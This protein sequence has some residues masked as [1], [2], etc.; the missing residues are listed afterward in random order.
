MAELN[1]APFADLVTRLYR[2]PEIQNTLFHLPRRSWH[3]P[4]DDAPDFSVQFHSQRAGNPIGPAAGPHTQM[5][6]NILLSYLAGSR[7]IELKTVQ[8]DDR[9]D[10]GRPCIDMT[11]VGYNIEFSQELLV[12]DSLREYVAGM[13]LIEMLRHDPKFADLNL[14]NPHGDVLY[15]T[16][17]GYDL[18]GIRSDKVQRFLDGLND[19]TV[20]IEKLRNQ[21]PTRFKHARDIDYPTQISTSVTLS[22]FHGCPADE[23]ERICT[24]LI[25]DRNL[26]VIVKMNPPMLGKD[27]LEHILHDQ[28][29]YTELTVNPSAY[30]T[31]LM[32][33]E[34]VAMNT[35]LSALA[36]KHNRRFGY[37]FSNTLEVINHRDFF[38]DDNKV[39]YLSGQPLHVIALTL[40]DI[41]RQTVGPNVPIT[42]SAGIDNQN[43]ADTV[44][45]GFVPITVSSD[46]LRPGGYGRLAVYFKRLADAMNNVNATNINDFVLD[47]FNQRDIATQKATQHYGDPVT[48]AAMLNTTIAAEN[49]RN[50]AR[51]HADK[52][53]KIQKRINSHLDVFDCIT[54]DKCIPV[55]P[56]AANFTY[57]TPITAFDHPD[58]VVQ[59]DGSVVE[60]ATRQFEITEKMQIACYAD[61]CNECGNCDTFCPEYGGP[62]IKK[63]SFFGSVKSYTDAAPRD[64]FVATQTETAAAIVGR[65]KSHEYHLD[66]DNRTATAQYNDGVVTAQI[67]AT[68]HT[69][70]SVTINNSTAATPNHN[71]DMNA[72]HTLRH[73]LAGVLNTKHVNQINAAHIT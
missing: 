13:M 62:Y 4:A 72:Y 18:A 64:G 19:A 49:A 40:T 14:A 43:I 22:T 56:N 12:Y 44:A 15:D 53:R 70:K 16:S 50:D 11:N 34:S 39:M 59:S 1:P 17:V 42:F 6:Q 25:T 26:D 68:N 20:E 35:R 60:S 46:L 48:C 38:T 24:F 45:C 27:R 69:I 2:E 8:I 5:A 57:P 31:G 51:Y 3:T 37:K 32:F 47:H 33:D 63:P 10:I 36:K 7:I 29:G 28:M 58:Y 71:I 23:I 73:L 9:L 55:C 54:C 67:D 21:I 41:F 30:T 65:I 66:I 61:F 52:N